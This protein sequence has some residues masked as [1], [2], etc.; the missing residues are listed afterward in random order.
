MLRHVEGNANCKNHC[1]CG[2]AEK[3]EVDPDIGRKEIGNREVDAADEGE[4]EDPEILHGAPGRIRHVDLTLHQSAHEISPRKVSVDEDRAED[5]VEDRGLPLDEHFV[6]EP[7]RESAEDDD[8]RKADPEHR[9]DAPSFDFEPADLAEGGENRHDGREENGRRH[10]CD[11]FA[12][13]GLRKR[14]RVRGEV[15]GEL[16]GREKENDGKEVEE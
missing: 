7:E 12:H 15:L 2:K 6:L 10:G 16:E 8:H 9:F 4:K 3:L 5:P 1:Q 14:E 11:A 13:G